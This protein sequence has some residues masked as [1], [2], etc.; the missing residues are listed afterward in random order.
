MKK[1]EPAVMGKAKNRQIPMKK[2][3]KPNRRDSPKSHP[4]RRLAALKNALNK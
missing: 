4:P 2:A 1:L 3:P